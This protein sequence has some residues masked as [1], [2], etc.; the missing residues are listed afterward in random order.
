MGGRRRG[1]FWEGSD[2]GWGNKLRDGNAVGWKEKGKGGDR[3][4][5]EERGNERM[6]RVSEWKE[7]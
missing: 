7:M 6:V 5:R 4:N 1:E 2:K 3:T